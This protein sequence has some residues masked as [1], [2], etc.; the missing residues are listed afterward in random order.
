MT[1]ENDPR[2]LKLRE[3]RE[4][5]MLGGGQSRIDKQHAKGKKTARERIGLLLDQGT[6]H[7]LDQFITSQGLGDGF[8]NV[9]GDGVVTGYG[10]INGRLVYLYAQDF[11][12]QGGALGEMHG[13]KICRAMDLARPSIFH[14]VRFHSAFK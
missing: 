10:R 4:K 11:T 13:Q 7:E 1:E 2:I 12:V 8:E 6:F 5:A 3:M 9:L 14:A